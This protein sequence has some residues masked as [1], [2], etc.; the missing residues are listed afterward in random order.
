MGMS[1][2]VRALRE[3]IGNDFLFLPSVATLIRDDRGRVLLVQHVEG[4]WQLPGGAVDPGERPEEAARREA[5]E[6]AGIVIET[7][8]IAGVFGGPEYSIT[9]DNGDETGWVITVFHARIVSGEPA[10]SD[11]ETQDVGWFSPTE[12]DALELHPATRRT[13]GILLTPS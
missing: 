5:R 12:L 7:T 9:Y 13:L 8:T 3:K 10:P 4:R 1:D 2:Y 6:E 11:D